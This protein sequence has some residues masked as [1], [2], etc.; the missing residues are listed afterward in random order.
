MSISWS[1]RTALSQH[2]DFFTLGSHYANNDVISAG[3]PLPDAATIGG[4]KASAAEKWRLFEPWWQF[5]R[6]TGYGQ[7][8]RIA[9]RD[10]YGFEE[11]S[12]ATLPEI[13][14]GDRG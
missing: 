2:V 14:P 11:I 5:A 6:F 1:K 10:I 13:E 8:L 3:L 12:G 9:I 7:A 4:D